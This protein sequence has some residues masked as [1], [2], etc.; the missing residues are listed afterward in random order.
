SGQDWQPNACYATIWKKATMD[1]LIRVLSRIAARY[2]NHPNFGG[3]AYGETSI[4]VA[5]FYNNPNQFDE[6]LLRESSRLYAAIRQ[7]G[8]SVQFYQSVNW[9]ERPYLNRMTN[10]LIEAKGGLSWPDSVVAQRNNWTW[11]DLG[12]VNN[13]NLL[14][15][16]H[17]E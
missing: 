16:P 15:A 17:A 9:K 8:P 5:S 3:I 2:N 13:Q 4:G 12:K 14:I 1:H 7:A 11:Y 10:T 6:D